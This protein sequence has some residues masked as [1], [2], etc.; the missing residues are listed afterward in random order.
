MTAPRGTPTDTTVWRRF[1][2]GRDVFA[3]LEADGLRGVRAI[4]NAEAMVELFLD[5]VPEMPDVVTLIIDD[6]RRD[7]VWQATGVAARDI[8]TALYA[9]RL[10]IAGAGGVEFT[11]VGEREQL[12]LSAHLELVAW[13]H[14]DRWALLMQRAGL[15]E[16][17]A[18]R[19]RLWRPARGAFAAAPD[20]S[21]G[22][23]GLVETFTMLPVRR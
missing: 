21:I 8:G 11:L 15:Q 16:Q 14:T 2:D 13:A 9:L 1:R 5:L 18:V 10:P 22:V 19:G 12:S 3:I 7:R 23:D 6:W 20:V 17:R 4:G